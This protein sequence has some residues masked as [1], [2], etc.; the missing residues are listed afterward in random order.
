MQP[1]THECNDEVVVHIIKQGIGEVSPSF[2]TF[3][4]VVKNISKDIGVVVGKPQKEKCK[5]PTA[6]TNKKAIMKKKFKSWC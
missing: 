1:L 2:E 4:H 6:K 5:K 3:G